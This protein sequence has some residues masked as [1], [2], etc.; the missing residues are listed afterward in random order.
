MKELPDD[1]GGSVVGCAEIVRRVGRYWLGL[2]W[3]WSRFLVGPTFYRNGLFLHLGPF[4]V[5][6]WRGRI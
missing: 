4:C 2:D 1:V 6:I 3:S 5:W